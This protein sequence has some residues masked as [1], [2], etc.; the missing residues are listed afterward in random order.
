MKILRYIVLTFGF[1]LRMFDVN[2]ME[3]A[4]PSWGCGNFVPMRPGAPVSNTSGNNKQDPVQKLISQIQQQQADNIAIVQRFANLHQGP[5]TSL[6]SGRQQSGSNTTLLGM[7]QKLLD[8]E[9]EIYNKYLEMPKVAA[10]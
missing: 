3:E 6:V 5:F 7:L 2:G 1:M 8:D 4:C 10:D 9:T